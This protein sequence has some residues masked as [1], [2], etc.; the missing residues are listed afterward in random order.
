MSEGEALEDLLDEFNDTEGV[1]LPH[2][3]SGFGRSA[4]WTNLA[5]RDIPPRE[6]R[7]A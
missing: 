2:G 7:G 5:S 6:C 1:T 3:G 4:G